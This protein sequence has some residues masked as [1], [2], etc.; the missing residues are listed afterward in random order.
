[1]TQLQP[2][3]CCWADCNCEAHRLE[4]PPGGGGLQLLCKVLVVLCQLGAKVADDVSMAE[5]QAG[6]KSESEL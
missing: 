1:M 4:K 5:L 2:L 6:S 3:L